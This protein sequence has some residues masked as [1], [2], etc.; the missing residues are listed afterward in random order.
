MDERDLEPEQAAGAAPR[1]SAPRLLLRAR[2]GRPDVVDLVGDVV[3]ARA[4]L[5]EEAADRCVLGERGEQLDATAA[6]AERG[7][8]DALVLE[9]ARCSSSAPKSR[10]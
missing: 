1:R 6:D 9:G 4:A 5:R 8:L 10:V 7:R 2:P 3:H